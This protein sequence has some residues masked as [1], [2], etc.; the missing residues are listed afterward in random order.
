MFTVSNLF[1]FYIEK[2]SINLVDYTLALILDSIF[3]NSKQSL[4]LLLHF[5]LFI[6][7]M[8]LFLLWL[9]FLFC[10]WMKY[11]IFIVIL[12]GFLLFLLFLFFM[13][14]THIHYKESYNIIVS[15]SAFYWLTYLL[16]QLETHPMDKYKSLTLLM[17]LNYACRQKLSIIVFWKPVPRSRLQQMEMPTAKEQGWTLF[18]R[19][20]KELKYL[21]WI[22]KLIEQCLLTW[23]FSSSLRLNHQ[24]KNI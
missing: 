19:V 22:E 24:F 8:L 15:I 4:I 6:P 12:S 10:S 23:S 1:Q 3:L 21:E 14:L 20:S 11:F 17:M 5:V 2:S 7:I 13:L 9:N 18:G 16:D